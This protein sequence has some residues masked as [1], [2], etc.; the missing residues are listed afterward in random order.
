MTNAIM[1]MIIGSAANQ[2]IAVGADG[3]IVVAAQGYGVTNYS[4]SA[5]Y[6]ILTA[7]GNFKLYGVDQDFDTGDYP[8]IAIDPNGMAVSV[9]ETNAIGNSTIMVN[10]GTAIGGQGN[11]T[12]YSPRSTDMAGSNPSITAIGPGQFVVSALAK[13]EEL[14]PLRLWLVTVNG[15]T[16]STSP[17]TFET[18]A[19]PWNLF[20]GPPCHQ[21]PQLAYRD[22]MLAISGGMT[23]NLSWSMGSLSGATYTQQFGWSIPSNNNTSLGSAVA[24]GPNNTVYAA[25]LQN[26]SAGTNSI[27]YWAGTYNP[28]SS[29]PSLEWTTQN[30][31]EAAEPLGVSL[32]CLNVG[33]YSTVMMAYLEDGAG[34][35]CVNLCTL[36]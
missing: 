11:L 20:S 23:S 9:H 19:G 30:T 31:V 32:A 14:W 15:G 34:A 27:M 21:Y 26:Q 8:S 4:L 22:G 3:T 33:D 6:G 36:S 12:Q 5:A 16:V 28:S 1:G 7:P 2:S 24:L 18:S 25:C 17:I 13:G 10:I 29:S 35:N